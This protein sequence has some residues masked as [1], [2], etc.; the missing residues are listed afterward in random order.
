[1]DS[2]TQELLARAKTCELELELCQKRIDFLSTMAHVLLNDGD[3][4][5][6]DMIL[7]TR[8][9]G[10][11]RPITVPLYPV[12][13]P[14]TMIQYYADDT[15]IP[16]ATQQIGFQ[17]FF[18]PNELKD[19]SMLT[20]EVPLESNLTMALVDI[21]IVRLKQRKQ[22]LLIDIDQLFKK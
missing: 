20:V 7:V 22:A 4:K 18:D 14:E 5:Y 19:D 11:A 15:P 9:K 10:G 13:S 12:A 3:I 16:E 8:P 17:R 2:K 1:M 21:A 6:V